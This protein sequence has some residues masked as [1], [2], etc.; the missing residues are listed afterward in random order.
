MAGTPP[1]IRMEHLPTV[2]RYVESQGSIDL[3]CRKCDHGKPRVADAKGAGFVP[4]TRF[5][6][7]TVGCSWQQYIT[8]QAEDQASQ[9]GVS[10]ALGVTEQCCQSFCLPPPV[11]T[12]P[13]CD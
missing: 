5:E 9:G 11:E 7:G 8:E 6:S 10:V 4:S 3:V 13:L 1:E 12:E 2:S